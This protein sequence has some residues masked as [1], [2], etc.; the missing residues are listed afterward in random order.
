MLAAMAM[1][2]NDVSVCVK[3]KGK[4]CLHLCNGCRG[5]WAEGTGARFRGTGAGGSRP[6]DLSPDADGSN[7][8]VVGWAARLLPRR[9]GV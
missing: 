8:V 2:V 4:R 9:V 1:Y 3:E 6:G 5:L 7:V